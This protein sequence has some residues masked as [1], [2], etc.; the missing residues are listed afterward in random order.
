MVIFY[1]NLLLIYKI[2]DYYINI[3]LIIFLTMVCL[4]LSYYFACYLIAL[5]KSPDIH[6]TVNFGNILLTIVILILTIIQVISLF[7]TKK[8]NSNDNSQSPQTSTSSNSQPL[9][10]TYFSINK[11]LR[12]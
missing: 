7:N 8:D 6:T 5:E 12:S 9:G 2:S 10:T 11:C 3:G 4:H 1:S